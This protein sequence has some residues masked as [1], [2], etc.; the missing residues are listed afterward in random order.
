MGSVDAQR[1]PNARRVLVVGTDNTIGLAVSLT[2]AE[3]GWLVYSLPASVARTQATGVI[4]IGAVLGELGG[5]DALVIASWG[6]TI[7][8]PKAV[9]HVTDADLEDGWEGAMQTMIWTLQTSFPA[10][11]QSN[12]SVV[13]LFPTTAMSGGRNYSLAAADRKSVV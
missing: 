13:V 4:D 2:L 7:T 12:G 10:L 11:V 9:E 3:S 8:A 6:P 1:Q 5:L